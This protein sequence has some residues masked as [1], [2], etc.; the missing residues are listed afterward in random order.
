LSVLL[1][2]RVHYGFQTAIWND[3][4][5]AYR[6]ADRLMNALSQLKK[7]G[8]D[9]DVAYATSFADQSHFRA[10]FPKSLWRNAWRLSMS[11]HYRVKRSISF[12]TG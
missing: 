6:L 2:R 5:A 12:Q 10:A 1:D 4:S 7:S 11:I 8:T 9:A 3:A